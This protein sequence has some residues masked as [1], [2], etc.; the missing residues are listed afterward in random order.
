MVAPVPACIHIRTY[1]KILTSTIY[2]DFVMRQHI[3]HYSWVD[4]YKCNLNVIIEVK[5]IRTG[6]QYIDHP[7]NIHIFLNIINVMLTEFCLLIMSSYLNYTLFEIYLSYS[8]LALLVHCGI[9]H[10]VTQYIFT[11]TLIWHAF[12]SYSEHIWW[13]I[14]FFLYFPLNYT[15]FKYFNGILFN[16]TF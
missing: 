14:F 15:F 2:L 9:F 8:F 12:V 4:H 16:N 10:D 3:H 13:D 1:I 6:L 11:K 5:V 7:V